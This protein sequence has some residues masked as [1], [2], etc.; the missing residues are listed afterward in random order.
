MSTLFRQADREIRGTLNGTMNAFGYFGQLIFSL[1][2]G[3]MFDGISPYAPFAFIGIFD[4]IFAITAIVLAHKG[5]FT[6]DINE[7]KLREYETKEEL[8][9]TERQEEESL[10]QH[11]SKDNIQ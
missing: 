4:F 11:V 6:D 9:L 8:K 3:F 7:R 5:I 2:G 1:V 10:N